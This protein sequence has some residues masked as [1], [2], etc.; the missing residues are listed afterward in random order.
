M[1][2]KHSSRAGKS[3]SM[4]MWGVAAAAPMVLWEMFF[5]WMSTNVLEAS[6]ATARWFWR[7]IKVKRKMD[8]WMLSP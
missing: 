8:G 4:D 1:M 2:P 6:M 7:R 3:L 5:P